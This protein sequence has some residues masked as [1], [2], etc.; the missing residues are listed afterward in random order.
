MRG[1][2]IATYKGG[3]IWFFYRYLLNSTNM[4]LLLRQARIIDQRS[5][6]HLQQ[7]DI[8]IENGI[9]SAIEDHCTITADQVI[10]LPQLH[11]SIGWMDLFSHFNDPGDEQRET[12]SS[13]VAAAAAGGFTDVLIV[14]N[15]KPALSSKSQIEYVLKSA[16]E[17]PVKIHP[18][19]AITKNIE[20]KEL[21]EMYDMHQSGAVAFSDG[22][23]P[24]QSTPL[25]IK[26]LQYTLANDTVLIQIP[27]DK[28]VS[29]HGLVNEGMVS[30][31]LGLPGTPALAEE[32]MV[33]RDIDLVRYTG[34]RLH[35]TGISTRKS[36]ELIQKAKEEG[37]AVSCSVTPYHMYFSDEDLAQYDTHLKVNPPLRTPDDRNFLLEAWKQ[38]WIDTIASHHQPRHTDEKNCE[39]EYAG[40]GMIGLES[41]FGVMNIVCNDYVKLVERLTVNNRNIIG[42]PVPAMAVGAE[43]CLTLFDPDV[44][45]EFNQRHI[46]SRSSNS[47]FIGKTLK[48]IVYGIYNQQQLHLSAYHD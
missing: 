13:G 32:L 25:L 26:A 20:G 45:Q 6:F 38:G 3:E 10:E 18:I 14:P 39:F 27:E 15:T 19:G 29:A 12:I 24:V 9:I 8:L 7:K 31:R 42:M 47:P 37:L 1:L 44:T 36:V 2:S 11:V 5:P 41:T 21:A 33:A 43:A 46:Y 23:V 30:T 34:A 28:G 22:W 17:F 35:L 4:K 48:G 16:V 40:Y